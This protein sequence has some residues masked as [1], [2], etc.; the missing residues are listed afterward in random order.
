MKRYVL[1]GTGHRGSGSYMTPIVHDLKDC[2]E[3]CGVYDIN[4]LRARAA[5]KI[6]GAQNVPVYED[7]DRM[8]AE[9]KPDAVIVTSVDATHHTYIIKALE[10]GC[11]VITEKPMTTD[12]EK[13][14]AII[15]AEKKS[16]KRVTVTFNCRYNPFF[17]RIKELLSDNAIGDVYSVHYEWM[18]DE[19]HGADYFRRWHAERKNSGSLLI[20]KASHHFDLLNWWLADDPEKVNAF[21]NRKF[22]VPEHQPHGERCY[23]CKYKDSCKYFMNIKDDG[24]YEAI[25]FDCEKDDGYY[26]DRCIF[27][28]RVDI[29][30]NVSVQIRYKKGTVASYTLTAHSP[31][32]GLKIVFNGENGRMEVSDLRTGYYGEHKVREIKVFDRQGKMTLYENPEKDVIPASLEGAD[33]IT[34]DVAG[35]HGGSDPLMRAVIFRDLKNDPLFQRAD[36]Y[37]GAM[38]IGIGAAANVSMKEDRAVYLKEIFDFMK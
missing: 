14:N 18:L 27:A 36:T 17:V 5:V 38:A 2:A 8:L 6:T 12:G 13:A 15:A 33:Q 24:L 20:H 35:G 3:L 4:T 7:F 10:A 23:T 30:D 19:R 28:D 1:V 26:R 16:G 21:G 34:I 25:Y 29:E 9:V 32:E 37:A 31:Y 11:D 22:Y